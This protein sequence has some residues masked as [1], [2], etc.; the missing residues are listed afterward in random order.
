MSVQISWTSREKFPDI[1]VL[2][3]GVGAWGEIYINLIPLF[4]ETLLLL[5][6]NRKL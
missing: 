3:E 4:M 1:K 2:S 5:N 6:R